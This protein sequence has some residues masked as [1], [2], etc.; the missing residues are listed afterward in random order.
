MKTT[1]R[2]SIRTWRIHP[3]DDTTTTNQITSHPPT[4]NIPQHA[5]FCKHDE[6][7]L[8]N[9]DKKLKE[10][11]KH[12]PLSTCDWNT[13]IEIVCRKSLVNRKKKRLVLDQYDKNNSR[14]L[15]LFLSPCAPNTV[16]FCDEPATVLV[17]NAGTFVV[18][19]TRVLLLRSAFFKKKKKHWNCP[20]Q[21]K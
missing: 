14:R 3:G 9:M 8:W 12:Y 6:S 7:R 20:L 18:C 5:S 16:R 19:Q 10:E 15:G 1:W 2:E 17:W 4:P 11:S 21:K 13:I